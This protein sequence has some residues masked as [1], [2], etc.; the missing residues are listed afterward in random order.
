MSCQERN[1]QGE[2][3]WQPLGALHTMARLLK[4]TGEAAWRHGLEAT[5]RTGL[6]SPLF[7]WRIR[8]KGNRSSYL[9]GT[10]SSRGWGDLRNVEG[11]V[12]QE[13]EFAAQT[14]AGGGWHSGRR[15]ETTLERGTP[16]Q[17]REA[18]SAGQEKTMG[19]DSPA[20]SCGPLGFVP[21]LARPVLGVRSLFISTGPSVSSNCHSVSKRTG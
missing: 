13:S 20:F 21:C 9:A 6:A 3:G 4:R 7:P 10:C 5:L 2:K 18:L 14:T 11:M 12:L 17:W 15:E 19:K 8:T 16:G 1:L